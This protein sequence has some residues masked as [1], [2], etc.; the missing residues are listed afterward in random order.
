MFITKLHYFGESYIQSITIT[1]LPKVFQ[2]VS[3]VCLNFTLIANANFTE[4]L[5]EQKKKKNETGSE[6]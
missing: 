2:N 5:H 6:S 1:F 4:T 3:F